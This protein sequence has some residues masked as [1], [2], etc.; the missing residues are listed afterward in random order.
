MDSDILLFLSQTKV[1]TKPDDGVCAAGRVNPVWMLEV[2]SGKRQNKASPNHIEIKKPNCRKMVA[3]VKERLQQKYLMR[4]AGPQ[5]SEPQSTELRT[6][7][8][9]P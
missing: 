9:E 6:Q 4:V 1:T 2:L 7:S 3:R 8:S 5:C